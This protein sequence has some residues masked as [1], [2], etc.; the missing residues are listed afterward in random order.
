MPCWWV[1]RP[2]KTRPLLPDRR[3]TR[4]LAPDPLV[5]AKRDVHHA[6]AP[7]HRHAV[8]ALLEDLEHCDVVGQHLRA[9]FLEPRFACDRGEVT[10][11]RLA[12][13]EPLVLVDHGE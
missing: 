5:E 12:D 7:P 3:R 10:H 1:W 4:G 2:T 8:A 11:K 9:D 13:P 6:A